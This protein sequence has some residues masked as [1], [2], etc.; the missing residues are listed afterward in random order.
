MD[1]IEIILIGI[2]I[3]CLIGIGWMGNR[4]YEK[5]NHERKFDGLWL[6]DIQNKST[7]LEKVRGYDEY[8]NWV[9]VN[10]K[11]MEY[12]KAIEVCQHEVGH[13]MFAKECGKNMSKCLEVIK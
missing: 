9:C 1:K 11:G 7:A 2:I 5:L 13:E 10:I 8:G 6:S 4:V 3:V 12:T